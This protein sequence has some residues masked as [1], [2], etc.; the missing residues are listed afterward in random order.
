MPNSSPPD[1]QL[2]IFK[3]P[4]TMYKPLQENHFKGAPPTSV[5]IKFIRRSNNINASIPHLFQAKEPQHNL[6]IIQVVNV[7]WFNATAWYGLW[8]A[9]LLR[10]AGHRCE[11]AALPGTDTWRKAEDWGFTPLDLNLNSG[12]PAR[13]AAAYGGLRR[14]VKE[15]RPHIVNCHR[16]EGFFLWAM[17][18]RQLNSFALVR[19]RGDQRRP[20]HDFC[21]KWLHNQAADA[22]I[23]TNTPMARYFENHMAT[24]QGHMTTILGGV[25]QNIFCFDPVGRQKVRREF[26]FADNETVVGLLGR[27]DT[28]KDQRGVIAACAL[29]RR[30]GRPARLMLLGEGTSNISRATVEAWLKDAGL[31][32]FAVITGRRQD[33]PACISAMDIGVV[34]SLGSETIARAALEIMACRRPLLSTTV[35]VMPD[36][37]PAEALFAPE[38]PAAMAE[39][40]ANVMDDPAFTQFLLDDAAKRLPQLSGP[41]FAGQTL[42][43][44]VRAMNAAGIQI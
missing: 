43:A 41:A 36:L 6:R 29:L 34:A 24:P 28:V 20:R 40:I 38:D 23:S 19:T 30:A 14:L 2:F 39:K 42:Q 17:L 18:R 1:R 15:Y 8:L 26:G 22:L 37:L 25:D 3:K 10:E 35:G 13:L 5:S 16:G 21:N 44:Y 33:V 9:R 31:A 27:L 12:N 7:R 32:E 4:K 11:V